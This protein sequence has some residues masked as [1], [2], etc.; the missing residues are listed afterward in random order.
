MYGY[1]VRP[2]DTEVELGAEYGTETV[3]LS[4]LAGP[5]G[6][7]IAVEAHPWTC[8]LLQ[9]TV[10]LNGLTNVAVVNAAA[11]GATGPVTIEDGPAEA[12][13]SHSVVRARQRGA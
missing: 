11:V 4:R 9:R 3:V 12:T 1:T 8:S 7:V 10:D 5:A 2:G 13:L 6:R